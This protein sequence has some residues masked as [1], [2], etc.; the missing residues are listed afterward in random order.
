MPGGI[1]F[2]PGGPGVTADDGLNPAE[3]NLLWCYVEGYPEPPDLD[4]VR[5][6]IELLDQRSAWTIESP[7]LGN[8]GDPE[9]WT[10]DV[11]LQLPRVTDPLDLQVEVELLP[12][13]RQWSMR[14][15]RQPCPQ[16]LRSLSSWMGLWWAGQRIR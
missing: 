12:V 3:L 4:T 2:N 9:D 6:V 7:T 10:L 15:N 14:W 1:R 16:L 11:L 8:E 5:Q 13:C